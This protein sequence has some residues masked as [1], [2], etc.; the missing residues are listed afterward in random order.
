MDSMEEICED[1]VTDL[2]EGEPRFFGEEEEE[3][4]GR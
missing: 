4:A 1:R 3:L 2:D